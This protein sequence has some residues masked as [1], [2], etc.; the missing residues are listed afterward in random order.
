M[1]ITAQILGVIAFSFLAI[2]FQSKNKSNMLFFQIVAYTIYVVQFLLL[3]AYTGLAVMVIGA[4]RSVILYIYAKKSKKV[5][6]L[7][8]LIF[9]IAIIAC[10]VSTYKNITDIFPGL[11]VILGTYLLSQNNLKWIRIG[12]GSI[13]IFWIIYNA[14]VGA[15]INIL[16]EVIILTSVIIGIIRY[17]IKKKKIKE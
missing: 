9:S 11:A 6:Y 2:S 13:C 1:N 12:E 16:A 8:P 3:G 7:L 10:V 17:D 4:I 14:A 5:N 15:Y